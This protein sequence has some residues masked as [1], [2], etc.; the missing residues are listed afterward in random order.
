MTLALP[1]LNNNVPISNAFKLLKSNFTPY[2]S[3]IMTCFFPLCRPTMKLRRGFFIKA[4]GVS[5]ILATIAIALIHSNVLLPYRM[6]GDLSHIAKYMKNIRKHWH[7]TT[8]LVHSVTIVDSRKFILFSHALSMSSGPW[9][10]TVNGTKIPGRRISQNS[11]EFKIP[12]RFTIQNTD[13]LSLQNSSG[14]IL[15][16]IA[17]WADRH[18]MKHLG[19][20]NLS[21]CIVAIVKN[22]ERQI[23]GFI[24]YHLRQGVQAI[25]VHDNNSS[26]NTISLS[27]KYKKV[28]VF[29]W[30]W[31]HT[32][33]EAYIHGNV[34]IRGVCIWSILIDADEFIFPAAMVASLTVQIM[35]T[36]FPLWIKNKTLQ[37]KNPEKVHQLCFDAKVMLSSRQIKWPNV[38]VPEAYINLFAFN[39]LGKCAVKPAK[40]I[41]TPNVHRFE[42]KGE[43]FDLPRET[44]YMYHYS[45]QCWEYHITKWEKGRS[46]SNLLDWDLK[47]LNR[48]NPTIAWT[49]PPGPLDTVF[50]DY[51][52]KV[53][54]WSLPK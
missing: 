27:Q 38:S 48:S 50:R 13:T 31:P 46:A 54:K 39:K 9:H 47:K 42:V 2:K 52:R 45:Y 14:H 36:S 20:S 18:G 28:I 12:R 16:S 49:G 17:K 15:P 44:A 23:E 21:V 19:Y 5:F 35:F 24:E 6:S 1:L 43:T 25:I 8:P 4:A 11:F 29:D 33:Q 10:C 7:R 53:Q 30:P 3:I 40:L 41:F 32:Q 34:Y 37:P 22:E 51:Y 26:D